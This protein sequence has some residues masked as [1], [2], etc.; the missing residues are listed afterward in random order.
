MRAKSDRKWPSVA[1]AG[2]GPCRRERRVDKPERVVP[3]VLSV[4]LRDVDEDEPARGIGPGQ[5]AIGARVLEDAGGERRGDG[6]AGFDL[7]TRHR[8]QARK[9]LRAKGRIDQSAEPA[10]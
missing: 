7:D 1:C 10:L 2:A 8:Q 3:R 5:R 4:G 9:F 6:N